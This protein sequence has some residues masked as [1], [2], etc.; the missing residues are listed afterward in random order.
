MHQWAAVDDSDSSSKLEDASR[1]P[2]AVAASTV[3]NKLQQVDAAAWKAL[4]TLGE[5]L[6]RLR[7]LGNHRGHDSEHA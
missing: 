5:Q 7:M 1:R 2:P 6:A 3:S 4:Q